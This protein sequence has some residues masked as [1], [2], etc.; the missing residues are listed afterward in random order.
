MDTG[1][2]LRPHPTDIRHP[3]SLDH[4]NPSQ[5]PKHQ[6]SF[7][8][9]MDRDMGSV[10]SVSPHDDEH[11]HACALMAPG[12]DRQAELSVGLSLEGDKSD[13]VSPDISQ[14]DCHLSMS[15][16]LQHTD[17]P[18]PLL[19]SSQQPKLG[20]RESGHCG[21]V[22]MGS[23]RREAAQLSEDCKNSATSQTA[24]QQN[25][26]AMFLRSS[27]QAVYGGEAFQPQS[28]ENGMSH[29]S[30]SYPALHDTIQ[31]QHVDAHVG[32]C[33]T[34]TWPGSINNPLSQSHSFL[35][36]PLNGHRQPQPLSQFSTADG[37]GHVP[38]DREELTTVRLPQPRTPQMGHSK[39]MD[40]VRGLPPP[41]SPSR[42]QESFLSAHATFDDSSL[43]A[44]RRQTLD[45]NQRDVDTAGGASGHRFLST[46]LLGPKAKS[47]TLLRSH[48]EFQPEQGF[49]VFPTPAEAEVES[50]RRKTTRSHN[51]LLRESST[52]A[53]K[54]FLSDN[55]IPL[56]DVSMTTG[57]H[58]LNHIAND[59][60]T[61][62]HGD[63]EACQDPVFSFRNQGHSHQSPGP[64]SSFAWQANKSEHSDL[65]DTTQGPGLHCHSTHPTSSADLLAYSRVPS[66]TFGPHSSLAET[67]DY[68]KSLDE[69]SNYHRPFGKLHYKQNQLETLVFKGFQVETSNDKRPTVE[70]ANN[71]IPSGETAANCHI[72]SAGD[73]SNHCISSVGTSDYHKPS[74]ESSAGSMHGGGEEV[75]WMEQPEAGQCV[76]SGP[77]LKPLFHE[78]LAATTRRLLQGKSP[79][80]YLYGSHHGYHRPRT[81][82]RRI[83]I[84]LA[85][86]LRRSDSG[87]QGIEHFFFCFFCIASSFSVLK[88]DNF[89]ACW[90]VV[91]D[92]FYIALFSALKQTHSACM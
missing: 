83:S 27:R 88:T 81:P 37:T 34:I 58:S 57:G 3:Q 18:T 44:D 82:A 92:R 51:P 64:R 55:S 91:V 78:D 9:T 53:V 56:S 21:S 79:P 19:L 67:S 47:P 63:F 89:S 87:S 76:T 60:D 16:C 50:S 80:A 61:L 77:V 11:F 70:G 5:L 10:G 42:N 52:R 86:P 12:N 41:F 59:R 23:Y 31:R 4:S 13:F 1:L 7:S 14:Q 36:V 29:S 48:S 54:G 38:Q 2:Q 90:V 39:F 26:R 69:T 68:H 40:S 15:R 85:Q 17:Q 28:P 66:E 65:S 24:Q 49:G 72:P 25:S 74:F 45:S 71:R 46:G 43:P 6:H 73:A 22:D 32:I 8:P 30:S 84:G 35:P 62:F 75:R 33:E 20:D